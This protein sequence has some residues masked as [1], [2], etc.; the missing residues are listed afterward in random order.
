MSIHGICLLAAI[1]A[2]TGGAPPLHQA[3]QP[4]PFT[5]RASVNS[6]GEE[7]NVGAGDGV[8]SADGRWLVFVTWANNLVPQDTNGESDVFLRDLESGL[9]SR[10]SVSSTGG[11]GDADS[12]SAH[13]SATGDVVAFSSS[14]SN[15]VAQDTNGAQDIFVHDRVT[16][17]TTL[18]SISDSGQQGSKGSHNEVLSADG[19]LV[20]FRTSDALVQADT[21]GKLDLYIHERATG[22]TSLV[23]LAHDGSIGNGHVWGSSLTPDGEFVAFSSEST[24]L[25]AG[26]P[27]GGSNVFV[28]N[29]STGAVELIGPGLEPDLSFDGRFVVFHTWSNLLPAEDGNPYSDIYLYDRVSQGYE[30][31]SA[32]LPNLPPLD[33]GA[34]GNADTKS[35]RPAHRVSQHAF[36][37]RLHD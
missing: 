14:A 11:E 29:L 18:V 34:F 9:T 25:V 27:T 16:G 2:G 5:F 30:L 21:N 33:I 26:G 19:S 6:R 3:Q 8:L 12:Y 13:L 31:I 37:N 22:A 4:N 20:L 15:L 1:Q 36:S 28:R 7:A 17:E 10:V 23:S 32:H 24:N 35:A